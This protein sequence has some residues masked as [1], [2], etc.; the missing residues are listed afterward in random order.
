MSEGEVKRYY[1]TEVA[2]DRALS[3]GE[4][5]ADLRRRARHATIAA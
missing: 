4:A 3:L 1:G 2:G 5:V